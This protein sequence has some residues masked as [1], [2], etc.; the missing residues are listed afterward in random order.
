MAVMLHTVFLHHSLGLE[1][2]LAVEPI[3]EV[4]L[5]PSRCCRQFRAGKSS[6]GVEVESVNDQTSD[7]DTPSQ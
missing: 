6:Q 1:D 5:I 2:V 4:E 3:L 7:I